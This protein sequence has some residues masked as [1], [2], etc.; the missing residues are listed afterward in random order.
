MAEVK[1]RVFVESD[2]LVG[3]CL[4]P[5]WNE[6]FMACEDTDP[7]AIE[8]DRDP[9]PLR[10]WPFN[11]LACERPDLCQLYRKHK[12]DPDNG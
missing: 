9:A 6:W 7:K 8:E 4:C 2:C 1:G 3:G 10:Q 5:A 12:D 11:P